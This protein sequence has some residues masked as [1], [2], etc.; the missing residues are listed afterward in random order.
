MPYEAREDDL[1]LSV[2]KGPGKG[3]GGINVTLLNRQLAA[4]ERA[5]KAIAHNDSG[6]CGDRAREALHHPPK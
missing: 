1:I 6:W 5:L 4:Y 2:D 3:E